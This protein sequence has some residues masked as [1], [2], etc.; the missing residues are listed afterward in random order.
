[1]VLH[2]FGEQNITTL[3]ENYF[4]ILPRLEK[5]HILQLLQGMGLQLGLKNKGFIRQTLNLIKFPLGRS[6][7]KIPR[8]PTLFGVPAFVGGAQ[9][10]VVNLSLGVRTKAFYWR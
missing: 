2:Y 10:R 4:P 1:L 6:K 8:V 5:N 9:Q 3:F 7:G